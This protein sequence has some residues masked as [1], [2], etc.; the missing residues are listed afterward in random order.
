MCTYLYS[1]CTYILTS[2]LYIC[3]YKILYILLYFCIQTFPKPWTIGRFVD[4][5]LATV[6][7][8]SDMFNKFDLYGVSV[9]HPPTI[10]PSLCTLG[11]TDVVHKT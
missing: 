1:V 4:I 2:V 6:N 11:Y 7:R 10:T 5:L 8:C 9:S 3:V